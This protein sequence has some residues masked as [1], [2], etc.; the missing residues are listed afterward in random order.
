MR[1]SIAE[2]YADDL[3]RQEKYRVETN[4]GR[5]M[6]SDEAFTKMFWDEKVAIK[7]A[8]YVMRVEHTHYIIGDPDPTNPWR[9]HGGRKFIFERLDT[10]ERIESTNVWY[11][12]QIP[13]DYDDLLPDNARIIE[14]DFGQLSVRHERILR[15]DHLPG[16]SVEYITSEENKKRGN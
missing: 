7:D 13:T 1:R 10:G 6:I 14:E 2:I 5:L 16:P 12:G 8:P 3:A 15:V 4:G 11:Q 9:G